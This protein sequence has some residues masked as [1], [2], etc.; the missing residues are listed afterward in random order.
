MVSRLV[1][2]ED[3]WR[4]TECLLVK[5][6]GV[7]VELVE[8]DIRQELAASCNDVKL[9]TSSSSSCTNIIGLPRILIPFP[10]LTGL[11]LQDFYVLH[12]VII[13]KE[14]GSPDDCLLF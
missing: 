8:V 1:V 12:E 9:S 11:I 7:L 10:D 5:K 6:V 2:G 14:T 13:L 4:I 3:I